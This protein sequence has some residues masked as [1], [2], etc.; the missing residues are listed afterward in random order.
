[1]KSPAPSRSKSLRFAR[2]LARGVQDSL[3]V[4][5]D[6]KL[7]LQEPG[8]TV[9]P[10]NSKG[11]TED[12]QPRPAMRRRLIEMIL[13]PR[14]EL[15][16]VP[17]RASTIDRRTTILQ[18]DLRSKRIRTTR[19]DVLPRAFLDDHSWAGVRRGEDGSL[20]IAFDRLGRDSTLLK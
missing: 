3:W 7:P 6:G 9:A 20:Q 18:V 13:A 16:L 8:A 2:N 17:S 19:V 12:V 15:W 1:M 5:L 4:P 14:G 10:T 11:A